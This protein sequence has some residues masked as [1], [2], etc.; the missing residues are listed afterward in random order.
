MTS[1]PFPGF[2]FPPLLRLRLVFQAETLIAPPQA[3]GAMWRGALGK[4][5][6]ESDPDTYAALFEPRPPSGSGIGPGNMPGPFVLDPAP[7]PDLVAAPGEPI[8]VDVTLIGPGIEAAGGVITGFDRAARG[9]LGK[10]GGRARLVD[11]APVWSD[12]P[13]GFPEVPPVPALPRH[14]MVVLKSPW[15]SGGEPMTQ[16][17]FRITAFAEAVWRRFRAVC[18][19]FGAGQLSAPLPRTEPGCGSLQLWA[20]PMHR[21]SA[22]SKVEDDMSGTMGSFVL[23]LTPAEAAFW[24]ALWWTQWTHIGAKTAFGQGA[25]RVHPLAGDQGAVTRTA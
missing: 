16:R 7:L 6:R 9:G 15:I 18:A 22:R 4:V 5:L 19:A 24:P 2:A 14:A 21:W 12:D 20:Q 25:V 8:E 3:S 17:S 1:D 10:G 11:W 13:D 23:Q